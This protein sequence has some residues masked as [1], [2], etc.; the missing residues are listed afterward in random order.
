MPL[1]AAPSLQ[2][3]QERFYLRQKTP[4]FSLTHSN[5]SLK[6]LAINKFMSGRIFPSTSF[7][8]KGNWEDLSKEGRLSPAEISSESFPVLAI[9]NP[10]EKSGHQAYFC[11]F[12]VVD[13]LWNRLEIIEFPVAG[14]D[15]WLIC[16][17]SF[18]YVVTESLPAIWG[19]TVTGLL[20]AGKINYDSYK[21]IPLGSNN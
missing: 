15:P 20:A 16:Q 4:N 7:L 14:S 12:T 13:L 21:T 19:Q 3:R 18:C 8:S 5:W 2:R 11:S 1:K 17:G 10:Q 6:R 9:L